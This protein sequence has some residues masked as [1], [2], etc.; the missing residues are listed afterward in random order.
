MS[1]K[2]PSSP[3]NRPLPHQQVTSPSTHQPTSPSSYPYGYLAN[4]GSPRSGPY[5]PPNFYPHHN[6]YNYYQQQMPPGAP[7]YNYYQP[8]PAPYGQYP[9]QNVNNNMYSMPPNPAALA[10]PNS[11]PQQP[12]CSY[13]NNY[14]NRNN[15]N[16]NRNNYQVRFYENV[17][18]VTT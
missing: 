2:S 16:K 8:P 10:H 4:N 5:P 7:A 6:Y 15:Y 17:Q 18:L 13:N 12:G 11:S 1:E 3:T 9:M 14:Q